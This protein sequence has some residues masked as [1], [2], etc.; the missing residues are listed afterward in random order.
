MMMFYN[1]S[2]YY[3]NSISYSNRV[4]ADLHIS[5]LDDL[6]NG[7]NPLSDY[8][9]TIILDKNNIDLSSLNQNN[10]IALRLIIQIKEIDGNG[11]SFYN[12]PKDLSF[13]P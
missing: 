13:Y 6:V 2:I 3:V 12:K 9:Y 5:S 4:D 8:D 11:H 7:S 1:S 10:L